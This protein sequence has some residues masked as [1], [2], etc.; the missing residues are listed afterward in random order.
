MDPL[1]FSLEYSD[2][3]TSTELEHAHRSLE[4]KLG[5]FYRMPGAVST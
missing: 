2:T 5:L 1:P 3:G 4:S